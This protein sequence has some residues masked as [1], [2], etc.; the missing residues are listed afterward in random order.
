MSES[1]NILALGVLGPIGRFA[2]DD[3][4]PCGFGVI[5]LARGFAASQHNSA[6]DLEMPVLRMVSLAPS[7]LVRD[8]SRRHRR[9]WPRC[10]AT[11]CCSDTRAVHRD[12]VKPPL[13]A[14]RDSPV[15]HP[16]DPYVH[17]RRGEGT[18]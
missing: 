2:S 9:Q 7:R 5:G 3:L 13:Q 6:P 4:C 12:F 8:R 15:R 1:R 11:R 17:S 16:S 10:A 14:I 18:H